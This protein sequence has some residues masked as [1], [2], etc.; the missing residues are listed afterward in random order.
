M[1]KHKKSGFSDWLIGKV[2]AWLQKEKGPKRAYLSDYDKIR[3][4]AQLGDVLLVEGRN[5]A[6]GIIKRLTQSPW[7]HAMLYIG[8]LRDIE[9]PEMRARATEFVPDNA[10]DDNRLVIESQLGQGTIIMP[11]RHYENEHLT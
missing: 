5:R 6:S 4:K 3:H 1:K 9:D 8:R 2:G 11:L 10:N 7:S